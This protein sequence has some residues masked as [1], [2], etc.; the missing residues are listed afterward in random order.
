MSISTLLQLHNST[1]QLPFELFAEGDDF[2][3]GKIDVSA[4]EISLIPYTW[5]VKFSIDSSQSM[6]ESCKD[7]KTKMQHI[8][9]TIAQILR[10]FAN[11]SS[12]SAIRFNVCVHSFDNDDDEI[13]DF[14]EIT[15]ENVNT[16]IEKINT[17]EPNSCTNLLNPITVTNEQMDARRILHPTN[18]QLHI[19]LT[20]GQDTSNNSREKITSE[21]NSAYD[22]VIIGFGL[23]HDVKTLTMI[24]S[25]PRCDY[26][27]VDI[28]ERA[29]MVYGECLH[30][31]LYRV[32]E[33]ITLTLENA[34][35]YNWKTNTWEEK[36][37]L[38]GISSGLIKTYYVRT[39]TPD[40]IA[41]SISGSLCSLNQESPTTE[42]STI[43]K[44]PDLLDQ[45][46][47]SVVEVNLIKDMFRFHT[48][49]LLYQAKQCESDRSNSFAQMLDEM[50]SEEDDTAP[51][52]THNK[53][54]TM[55]TTL[56]AFF[57]IIKTY[58]RENEEMEDAFL[59]NLLDDLYIVYKTLGTTYS[60]VYSTAR[61]RSQG[62]QNVCTATQIDDID[63]QLQVPSTPRPPRIL[64]PLRLQRSKTISRRFDDDIN[65]HFEDEFIDHSITQN[66]QDT[67][68]SPSVT[69]LMR[70]VS[71]Y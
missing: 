13:F 38:D 2:H 15:Q 46:T 61:Y 25:I 56:R 39:T 22:F 17:I 26:A 71:G 21:V 50:E 30:H 14:T 24:S 1:T 7:G 55:R 32:A 66:T 68:A 54:S 59:K 3:F 12:T 29:G 27:F 42:L 70:E 34:T 57:N 23:E 33:N 51:L 48:M 40:I 16:Y 4:S 6:E 52:H 20:D 36:L 43:D 60:N 5:D 37:E 63:L 9:Y 64:F 19:M 41:G 67:Y 62:R 49:E 44:L 8:K 28:L 31:I 45:E 47:S 11:Y 53:I 58:M 35:I 10:T 69:K 18:K 65:D